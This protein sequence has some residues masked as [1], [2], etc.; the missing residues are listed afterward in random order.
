LGDELGGLKLSGGQLIA[1][2]EVASPAGL[3]GCSKL[4][5]GLVAPGCAA[6]GV[7][8]VAGIPQRRARFG[9]STLAA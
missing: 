6:H 3:P 1:G 5:A 7:E 8:G 9:D 2:G 4:T